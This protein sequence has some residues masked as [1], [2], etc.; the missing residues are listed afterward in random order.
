[1]SIDSQIGKAYRCVVAPENSAALL[2]VGSRSLKV[3][4]LDTSR[5]GFTIRIA[6]HDLDRV[7]KAQK[8]VLRFAE[9]RWEVNRCGAYIEGGKC[10]QL[11]LVRVRETTR[12]KQPGGWSWVLVPQFSGQ[13]DPTL[14]LGLLV[15]FLIACVCLPGIGDQIGTAPKVSRTVRSFWNSVDKSVFP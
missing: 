14:L 2:T 6:N 11:S 5:D 15:A 13:K 9:E 10:T 7:T 4:V 3:N 8:L 1:M 12:V